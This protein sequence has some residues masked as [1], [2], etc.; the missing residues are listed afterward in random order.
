MDTLKRI[1]AIHD[2]SGFGKC[3]LS[4]ALPVISAAG[5]ECSCIPTAV[6]STHTAFTNV[7]AADLTDYMYAIAKHWKSLDIKFDGIYSGYLCSPKQADILIDIINLLRN[8]DTLVIIDPV[9]ADHGKYYSNLDSSMTECFRN[10]AK[11]SDIIT[12]N[13]TE[14]AFLLGMQYQEGPY[15]EDYVVYLLKKLAELGPSKV[16]LTGVQFDNESIGVACFDKETSRISYAFSK[17]AH[18]S[19]PGTGDLFASALSAAIIKGLPTELALKSAVNMV[20]NS[21]ENTL[22]R[23]TPSKC[24]VDFEGALPSFI[25]DLTK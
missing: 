10:I 8:D 6:L 18:A 22:L 15:T 25:N 5:I 19:F 1:A 4:I 7:V 20:Y 23:G 21:I 11:V 3:S 17:K 24:G 14:A 16:V 12:P 2:L 9:M 13:F